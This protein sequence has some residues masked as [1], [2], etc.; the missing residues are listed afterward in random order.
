MAIEISDRDLIRLLQH[1]FSHSDF[2]TVGVRADNTGLHV[3]SVDKSSTIVGNLTVPNSMT[4]VFEVPGTPLVTVDAEALENSLALPDPVDVV[5]PE[6][7]LSCEFGVNYVGITSR[8][9]ARYLIRRTLNDIP[10]GVRRMPTLPDFSK[11]AWCTVENPQL[12]RQVATAMADHR[13]LEVRIDDNRL[14]FARPSKPASDAFIILDVPSEGERAARFSRGH[15][16][17]VSRVHQVRGLGGLRCELSEGGFA[18][19]A[20]AYGDA[21]LYYVVAPAIER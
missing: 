2:G 4:E 3:F 1:S 18:R 11:A 15:I 16:E 20:Y 17:A 9:G 8:I 7:N 14:S 19:F 5:S 21:S 6:F 12:L 13:D 10:T